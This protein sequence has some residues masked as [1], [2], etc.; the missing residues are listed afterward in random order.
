MRDD[1]ALPVSGPENGREGPRWHWSISITL[2]A[3]E[4]ELRAEKEFARLPGEHRALCQ[5]RV[6]ERYDARSAEQPV[7]KGGILCLSPSA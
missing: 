1:Y 4:G 6:D 7:E 5:H 3:R 2:A